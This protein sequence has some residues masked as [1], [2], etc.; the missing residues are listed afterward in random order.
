MDWRA[1]RPGWG[2]C[3]PTVQ[4]V[5]PGV[6]P[7]IASSPETLFQAAK[8]DAVPLMMAYTKHEGIFPLDGDS[9]KLNSFIKYV[10]ISH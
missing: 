5:A 2:A 6:S 8:Y 4:R 1:G 3:Q 10:L 7:I 9:N